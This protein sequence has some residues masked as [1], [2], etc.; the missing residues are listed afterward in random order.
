MATIINFGLAPP[1][2]PMFGI[3]S[4]NIVPRLT[5]KNWRRK[6][7]GRT[8]DGR[9]LYVMVNRGEQGID[10]LKQKRYFVRVHLGEPIDQQLN[11]DFD[12]LADALAYA[13]GE[14]NT[15]MTLATEPAASEEYPDNRGADFFI[16]GFA[17][18]G[19]GRRQ[20]FTIRLPG[21]A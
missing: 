17:G 14:G 15:A 9:F 21:K 5:Q 10:G 6:A 16:T 18:Q 3:R 13:N 8:R 11:A 4:V 20:N 7:T 2:D 1:H 19:R 12:K